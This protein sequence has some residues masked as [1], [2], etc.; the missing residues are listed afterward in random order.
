[1][2]I[3]GRFSPD[4]S[5]QDAGFFAQCVSHHAIDLSLGRIKEE[6]EYLLKDVT[7]SVEAQFPRLCQDSGSTISVAFV[8]PGKGVVSAWIGDSEILVFKKGCDEVSRVF[9][10]EKHQIASKSEREKIKVRAEDHQLHYSMSRSHLRLHAFAP[11]LALSESIGDKFLEPLKGKAI[12]SH[13]MPFD[14][15]EAYRVC[16]ASDGLS[17]VV[18]LLPGYIKKQGRGGAQKV[19]D[20][21]IMQARNEYAEDDDIAA[22]LLE[23]SSRESQTNEAVLMMVADG[24]GDL[25]HLVAEKVVRLLRQ[26]FPD[27]LASTGFKCDQWSAFEPLGKMGGKQRSCRVSGSIQSGNERVKFSQEER[28]MPCF[29][30][31]CNFSRTQKKKLVEGLASCGQFACHQEGEGAAALQ[32]KLE[33]NV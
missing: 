23:V 26:K 11:G 19:I 30:A 32:Q 28:E 7:S 22:F 6:L 3:S 25:G 33:V 20:R 13:E 18:D 24:H 5:N 15:S 10:N 31:H 8:L 9:V 29:T 4:R 12:S 17:K 27:F 14:E 16:V 2:L 1:M 21:S